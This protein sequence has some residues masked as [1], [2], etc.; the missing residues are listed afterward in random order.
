[1]A[2]KSKKTSHTTATLREPNPYAAR[3][4][5]QVTQELTSARQASMLRKKKVR[6]V[7]K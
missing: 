3:L 4:A 5:R 1:M 2:T 7:G 6:S